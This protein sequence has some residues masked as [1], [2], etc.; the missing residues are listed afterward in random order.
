MST[1]LRNTPTRRQ[2]QGVRAKGYNYIVTTLLLHRTI[3]GP[4]ARTTIQCILLVNE[5]TARDRVV[6]TQAAM[7]DRD[8]WASLAK[9][10]TLQKKVESTLNRSTAAATMVAMMT[11]SFTHAACQLVSRHCPCCTVHRHGD[12]STSTGQWQAGCWPTCRR[13]IRSLSQGQTQSQGRQRTA[14]GT[15]SLGLCLRTTQDGQ[16]M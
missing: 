3:L 5:D 6:E 14:P 13:R 4:E 10:T 7:R 2:E 11:I 1:S 16:V 9:Q 12:R 8:I 15:S